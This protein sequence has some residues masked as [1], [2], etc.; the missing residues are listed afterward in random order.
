MK[1]DVFEDDKEV[2]SRELEFL[3][4]ISKISQNFR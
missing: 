2:I 4:K 1:V 3:D